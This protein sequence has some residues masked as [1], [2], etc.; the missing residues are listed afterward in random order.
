M[1]T[2]GFS[3]R[4]ALAL[5]ENRGAAGRDLRD[6][7]EDPQHRI[8]FA[9]DVG[10]VVA[11]LEGALEL[12]VFFFGPVASNGGA[13][14]G[15]QLLVVP[16]FLNEVLSACPDGFDDVIDRAIGCDHDDRQVGLALLELR[17]EL[18]AALPRK[19]QVKQNEVEALVVDPAQS[20]FAVD[21]GFHGVVFQREQHFKRFADAGLVVNHQNGGGVTVACGRG[22]GCVYGQC[23][24]GSELRHGRN[25]LIGETRDE[26]WCRSRPRFRREFCPHA[27]G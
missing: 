17:Q 22:G 9:H 7:I 4:G 16:G 6:Q 18:E 5:N 19:S 20:F 12:Q 21:R 10:E 24:L 11:L 8:A 27:P 26:T 23:I 13:D 14:V 25:S 1:G 15:E 3:R 2:N